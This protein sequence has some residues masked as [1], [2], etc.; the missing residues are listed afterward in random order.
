MYKNLTQV[1]LNTNEVKLKPL[2]VCLIPGDGFLLSGEANESGMCSTSLCSH[3]PSPIPVHQSRSFP[4]GSLSKS[5]EFGTLVRAVT[6]L[7]SPTTFSKWHRRSYT[8]PC[9]L[10]TPPSPTTLNICAGFFCFCPR[11]WFIPSPGWLL[12][13]QLRCIRPVLFLLLTWLQA[14]FAVPC[15]FLP[16][17]CSPRPRAG[18]QVAA[19]GGCNVLNCP[20]C[21]SFCSFDIWN[22]SDLTTCC[23]I[24]YVSVWLIN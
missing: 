10:A 13:T 6:E 3:S 19:L 18:V 9:W 2:P 24:H 7:N 15:V 11:Q 21:C 14:L 12:L 1:P 17:Q 16:L 4:R 20:W 23:Q 22:G 5:Q 8:A